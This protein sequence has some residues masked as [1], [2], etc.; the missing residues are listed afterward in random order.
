M[1]WAF[2]KINGCIFLSH[3]ATLA[4][5]IPAYFTADEIKN[6]AGILFFISLL[7][8]QNGIILKMVLLLIQCIEQIW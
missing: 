7:T 1:L 5:I 8:I 6:L 3:Q 2:Q 4:Q